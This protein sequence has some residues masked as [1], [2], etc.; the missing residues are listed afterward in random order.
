MLEEAGN[1]FVFLFNFNIRKVVYIWYDIQVGKHYE[2]TLIILT[3][4]TFIHKL[5]FSRIKKLRIEK[6]ESFD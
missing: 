1:G 5:F 6:T 3:A 2:K 4:F